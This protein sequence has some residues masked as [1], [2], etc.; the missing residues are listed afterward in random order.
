MSEIEEILEFIDSLDVGEVDLKFGDTHLVVRKK[1]FQ[2]D[3][4]NSSSAGQ[5]TRSMNSETPDAEM[6][7][8]EA[9]D[10]ETSEEEIVRTTSVES[11]T[12]R[13]ADEAN[14]LDREASGEVLIVRSPMVG[15]FYRAKEP[16]AAPFVEVGMP[17]GPEDVVCL[18][19]VMKLFHSVT[20][21]ASGIVEVILVEDAEVVEHGQPLIVIS[22]SS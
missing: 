20:A 15:T 3:M 9:V 22:P 13:V 8:E 11:S 10:T 17:V 5:R 2:G 7:S 21:G 19:E 1:S 16:G 18:V 4:A 12:S 14:W 6:A